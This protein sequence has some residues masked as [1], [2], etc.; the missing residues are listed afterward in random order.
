MYRASEYT[1]EYSIV[2][3]DCNSINF[4]LGKCQNCPYDEVKALSEQ[5][6]KCCGYETGLVLMAKINQ[7]LVERGVRKN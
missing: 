2:C 1:A 7:I 6:I 5:V 3:P 4:I